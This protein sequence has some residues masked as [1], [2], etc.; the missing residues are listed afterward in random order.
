MKKLSAQKIT[1]ATL[2]IGLVTTLGAF[3]AYASQGPGFSLLG[4]GSQVRGKLTEAQQTNNTQPAEYFA[5][6]E[7]GKCGE[8]K[9]GE[10]KCGE[11]EAKK[12]GTKDGSEA[13][14]GEGKCGEKESGEGKCGEGKCGGK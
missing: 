6:G 14:C 1:T 11:K 8:G 5:K 2:S 13:K 10:G 12:D 3:S 9:C 4:S 7:E